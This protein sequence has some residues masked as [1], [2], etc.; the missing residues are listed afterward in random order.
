MIFLREA[1]GGGWGGTDG[2]PFPVRSGREEKGLSLA[3]RAP[4]MG[5]R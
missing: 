2:D 1:W 3:G 4:A 5:N